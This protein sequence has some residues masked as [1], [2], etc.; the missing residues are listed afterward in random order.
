[1]YLH[2]DGSANGAQGDGRLSWT[3]PA[4]EAGPAH[5]HY[6]Y[7]PSNPVPSLGGS[8]CCGVATTSGARD[9][10]PIEHRTDILVYTSEFLTEDLEVVGPVKLVLHAASNAV[11]T[12]FVAKLVDVYPDGRSI[13]IAEGILPARYRNGLE[14]SEPLVPGEVYELEVDLIGT[15]NLFQA[16][17]RIRVHV[18]SSHFPQFARN[19]NTGEPL[20]TGEAMSVAEQTIHHSADRPSH[21]LLPVIP[22]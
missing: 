18:T 15:A 10:R 8:N 3:M 13:N 1:L 7:D 14:R 19:L 17:H 20:G 4:S 12:D 2:S 21:I 16:G 6:R 22:E 5:D 9:Q 11:D